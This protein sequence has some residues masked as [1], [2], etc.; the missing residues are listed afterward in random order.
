MQQIL[1]SSS[2]SNSTDGC[3]AVYFLTVCHY[4]LSRLTKVSATTIR[5]KRTGMKTQ[6]RY[7][8]SKGGLLAKEERKMLEEREVAEEEKRKHYFS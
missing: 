2:S 5:G 7:C 1:F 4:F 3:I 8:D 6:G